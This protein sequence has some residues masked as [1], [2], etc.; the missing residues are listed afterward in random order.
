MCKKILAF[1]SAIAFIAAGCDPAG[2]TSQAQD[3]S[4]GADTGEVPVSDAASAAPSSGCPSPGPLSEIFDASGTPL[5]FDFRH[6]ADFVVRSAEALGE[7]MYKVDLVREADGPYPGSIS[8]MQL[9][10][11]GDN[12][13]PPGIPTPE[14]VARSPA[15]QAMADTLPEPAET[16]G[17]AGRQVVT[18]RAVTDDKVVYKFNLPD[19]DGYQTVDV[20]F[21]APDASAE[22]LP[23]TQE[24]ASDW[25]RQLTPRQP[26]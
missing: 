15:L 24:L 10:A 13:M 3:S 4:T 25:V 11:P 19:G 7:G 16:I 9:S 21:F 18:Y 23:A 17:F 8:V 22:C 1:A 5:V 14:Q 26:Q 20:H 6:P 12:P 2:E